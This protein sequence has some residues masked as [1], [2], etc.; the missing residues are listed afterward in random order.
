M[1]LI[2]SLNISNNNKI[3]I[4]QG[5]RGKFYRKY[6]NF[7]QETDLNK[8]IVNYDIHFPLDWSFNE[9]EYCYYDGKV[10]QTGPENCFNC[11]NVGYYNGV[12]VAYCL[13]CA[14]EFEDQYRGN[15]MIEEGVEVKEDMV[16]FDLSN[17]KRENSIWNTY[18]KDV[19]LDEIGDSGLK[20]YHDMYKD[21]PDLL[22]PEENY[23][24]QFISSNSEMDESSSDEDDY[25]NNQIDKWLCSSKRRGRS[26]S[27]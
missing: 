23:D 24:N 7:H 1:S 25:V 20:E 9:E 11:R 26:D 19:S 6:F 10:C 18:L 17:F 14:A 3:F 13:N 5:S 15:G 2:A 27:F 8:R 12:F 22:S 21:L 16:A 4:F